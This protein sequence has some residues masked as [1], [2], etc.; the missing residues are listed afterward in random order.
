MVDWLLYDSIYWRYRN[1]GYSKPKYTC[2]VK[3][4]EKLTMV[5]K[6]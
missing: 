5:A 1:I 2:S 4:M 3:S 6:E